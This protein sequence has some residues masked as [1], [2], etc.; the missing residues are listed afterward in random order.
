MSSLASSRRRAP[1]WWSWLVGSNGWRRLHSSS[2]RCVAVDVLVADL[3]DRADVERVARRVASAT[4][5]IDLLVN[6]AGV[7]GDHQFVDAAI[8]DELDA[9]GV[10]VTALVALSHAAARRMA[11]AGQGTIVNVSSIAGNQ[12]RGGTAVY[13][14]A[15]AFVTAFSQSLASELEGTGVGCTVVLPGLT[16]TEFHRVN[17]IADNS[18]R[19]LWMQP[20]RS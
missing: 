17:G 12:P 1:G 7:G 14:A 9:I 11:A 16:E 10:N 3:S 5:P 6:N 20:K 15:K 2:N 19:A 4:E 18:P 13:G 8:E